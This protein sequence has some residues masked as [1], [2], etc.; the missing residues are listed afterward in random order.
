[1]VDST[2]IIRGDLINLFVNSLIDHIPNREASK[3]PY[4]VYPFN[5]PDSPSFFEKEW[6]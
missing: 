3:P 6:K 1:M 5:K 4:L 2:S